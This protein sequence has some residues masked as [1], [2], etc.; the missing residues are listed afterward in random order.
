MILLCPPYAETQALSPSVPS[1]ETSQNRLAFISLVSSAWR[2]TLAFVLAC[3]LLLDL[4]P[5]ICGWNAF[6]PS[7]TET[8]A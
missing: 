8:S 1:M 4:V 5:P 7:A 2:W 6:C 3:V